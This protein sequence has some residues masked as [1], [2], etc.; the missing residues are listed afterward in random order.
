MC[1]RIIYQTKRR[2]FQKQQYQFVNQS[3][4]KF[5]SQ[6]NRRLLYMPIHFSLQ[7][8]GADMSVS[9]L[10]LLAAV[11]QSAVAMTGR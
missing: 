9:M 5:G 10:L 6:L 4:I 1:L 11:T 3:I 2:N 8:A 7:M